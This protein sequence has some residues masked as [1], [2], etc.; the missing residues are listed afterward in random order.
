MDGWIILDKPENISSRACGAR[1]M[2]MFDAPTFGHIGTLDPMAS[3][4]LPIAL[5][6]AT[7]VIPFMQTEC[8]K[9]YL[10]SMQFGFETDT[11]DITGAI[12]KRNDIIPGA[13][14]VTAVL[15]QFI[16]DIDQVPPMYS[17]VHVGGVRAHKLARASLISRHAGFIFTHWNFWGR[18]ARH[19]I[20][21]C[22]APPGHMCVHWGAISQMR[23]GH[24]RRLT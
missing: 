8:V 4:L 17:A 19:T 1:C 14:A 5:G 16:G 10:F 15:S 20:F 11:L 9:E 2:R 21:G 7:R 13:D 18:G 23:A 24:W 12:T 22:V 6:A 3:G